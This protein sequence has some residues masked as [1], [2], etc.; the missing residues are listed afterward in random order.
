M[1]TIVVSATA[2]NE[3]VHRSTRPSRFRLANDFAPISV[4]RSD[5]GSILAGRIGLHQL[6]RER[7]E[8]SSMLG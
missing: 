4:P 1:L 6:Q 5:M 8:L 7:R 2:M 3:A